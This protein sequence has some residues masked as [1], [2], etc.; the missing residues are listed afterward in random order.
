MAKV[1]KPFNSITQR[2][3]VGAEVSETDNLEPHSFD[4]LL[5]R[6]FIVDEPAKAAVWQSTISHGDEA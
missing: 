1:A 4:D 5:E 3:A 6:G 2:F